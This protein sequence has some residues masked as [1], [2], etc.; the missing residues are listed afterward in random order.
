[1]VK[2]FFSHYLVKKGMFDGLADGSNPA[3]K[4]T[5][6]VKYDGLVAVEEAY[7]YAKKIISTVQIPTI[8]DKFENDLLL[9][10]FHN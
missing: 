2:G 3:Q 4:K 1:M 10:Y 7:E 5:S 6:P 8:S 9:W